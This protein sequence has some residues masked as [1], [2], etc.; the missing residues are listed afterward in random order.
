MAGY[1]VPTEF[2]H[3]FSSQR[4]FFSKSLKNMSVSFR[5]RD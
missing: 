4:A 3:T 1:A 5:V 2:F